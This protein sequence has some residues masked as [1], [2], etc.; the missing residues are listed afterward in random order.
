MNEH[1]QYKQLKYVI[2]IALMF[3]CFI[4]GSMTN[5]YI[6]RM[7]AIILKCETIDDNRG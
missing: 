6:K 3:I 4:L 1:T 5:N 7:D 2:I